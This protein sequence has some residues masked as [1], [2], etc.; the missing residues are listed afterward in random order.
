MIS[1]GHGS[2]DLLCSHQHMLWH[3]GRTG[4]V[5]T[6]RGHTKESH[7][8]MN[9]QNQKDKDVLA[10]LDLQPLEMID[11]KDLAPVIQAYKRATGGGNQPLRQTRCRSCQPR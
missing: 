10:R 3:L 7:M 1:V 2:T 8:D 11:D 9:Y 4:H 6:N 5:F